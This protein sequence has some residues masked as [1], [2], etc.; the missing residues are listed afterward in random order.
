MLPEEHYRKIMQMR[1]IFLVSKLQEDFGSI[2]KEKQTLKPGGKALRLPYLCPAGK[3]LLSQNKFITA[4]ML[5]LF[6]V[7]PHKTD[8]WY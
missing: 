8:S 6:I 4:L 5:R 7:M 3:K 2:S 1:H